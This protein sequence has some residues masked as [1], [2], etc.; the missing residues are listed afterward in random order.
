MK[1]IIKK[2]KD[3]TEMESN[4]LSF[5]IKEV[6]AGWFTIVINTDRE[7]IQISDSRYLV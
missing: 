6:Q 4:I 7:S 1:L 2:E 3:D 5:K